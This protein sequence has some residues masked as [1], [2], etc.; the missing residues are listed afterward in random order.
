[1]C[2]SPIKPTPNYRSPAEPKPTA[3]ERETTSKWAKKL[4]NVQKM[5]RIKQDDQSLA[6]RNGS[7]EEVGSGRMSFFSHFGTQTLKKMYEKGG[8]GGGVK[9]S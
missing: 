3:A 5:D 1:M 9:G 4:E 7:D 6:K 8:L 2:V